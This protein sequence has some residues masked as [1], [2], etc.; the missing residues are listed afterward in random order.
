MKPAAGRVPWP[1]KLPSFANYKEEVTRELEQLRVE[2]ERYLEQVEADY[3]AELSALDEERDQ[4]D[5]IQLAELRARRATMTPEQIGKEKAA[6]QLIVDGL[7][8]GAFTA[9]DIINHLRSKS[10]VHR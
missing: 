4:E 8:S 10:R 9:L 2:H 3:Q 6:A 1:R 7:K 5:A